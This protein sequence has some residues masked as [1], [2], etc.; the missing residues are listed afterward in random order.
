MASFTTSFRAH[1]YRLVAGLVLLVGLAASALVA[2]EP[3]APNPSYQMAQLE[4][5]TY[6]YG[7]DPEP[8][9]PET[10]LNTRYGI[11]FKTF[12]LPVS[13]DTALEGGTNDLTTTW[14]YRIGEPYRQQM[15][16]TI[17]DP[18]VVVERKPSLAAEWSEPAAVQAQ[19]LWE[20]RPRIEAPSSIGTTTIAGLSAFRFRSGQDEILILDRQEFSIIVVR[21]FDDPSFER[22]L[23]SIQPEQQEQKH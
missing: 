23:E 5:F 15:T 3:P 2:L 1:R 6:L 18:E 4:P 7:V 19:H 11:S 14:S 8:T 9:P 20:D 17:R 21:P 13:A 16:I 22:V 10:V 12:G